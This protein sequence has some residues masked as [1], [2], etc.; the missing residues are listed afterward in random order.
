MDI[1]QEQCLIMCDWTKSLIVAF[2]NIFQAEKFT[3][4]EIIGML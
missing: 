3:C 2:K 4:R 1:F